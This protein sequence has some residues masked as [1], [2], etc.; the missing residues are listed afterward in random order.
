MSAETDLQ[1]MLDAI[2]RWSSDSFQRLLDL[3]EQTPSAAK[4][5]STHSFELYDKVYEY[6]MSNDSPFAANSLAD[7][8]TAVRRTIELIAANNPPREMHMMFVEKVVSADWT[9]E[10]SALSTLLYSLQLAL[11]GPLPPAL[12]REGL[13]QVLK[14]VTCSSADRDAESDDYDI[15]VS[16]SQSD[17]LEAKRLSLLRTALGFCA[18][19]ALR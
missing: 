11:L 16:A 5:M 9:M 18:A 13:R 6:A 2:G 7:S 15:P 4:M 3:I 14:A 19:L 10:P 17:A 12:Y 1:S 8:S